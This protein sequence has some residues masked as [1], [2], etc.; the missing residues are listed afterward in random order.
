MLTLF[1][2]IGVC[3]LLTSLGIF[4]P[5][6]HAVLT[7]FNAAEVINGQTLDQLDFLR[8]TDG[9]PAAQLQGYN[10]TLTTLLPPTVIEIE[11]VA[12]LQAEVFD[13]YNSSLLTP[14]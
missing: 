6:K 4:T 11:S 13:S 3:A 8:Q 12:N 9:L 5:N 7:E 2:A 10:D 14:Q 1:V